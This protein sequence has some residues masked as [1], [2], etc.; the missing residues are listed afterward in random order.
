MFLYPLI[1]AVS[2]DRSRASIKPQ[3]I[4]GTLAEEI[5]KPNKQTI[6][7]KLKIASIIFVPMPT[8]FDISLYLAKIYNPI[9]S[10]IIGIIASYLLFDNFVS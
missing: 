1:E 8:F 6:V 5:S 2:I 9:I 7:T 10:P 4:A 3:N